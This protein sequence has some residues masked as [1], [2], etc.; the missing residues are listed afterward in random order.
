MWNHWDEC[1][2]LDMKCTSEILDIASRLGLQ[3]CQNKG[4]HCNET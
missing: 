3:Y 2:V 1:I 4:H